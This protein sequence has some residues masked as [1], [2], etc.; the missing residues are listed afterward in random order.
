MARHGHAYGL[1]PAGYL[2]LILIPAE[3]FAFPLEL[4][5]DIVFLGGAIFVFIVINP[6]SETITKISMAGE[7][8][9]LLNDYL[10][11]RVVERTR[12]LKR[13]QEFV[14]TVLHGFN[15]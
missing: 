4:L 2:F 10:E 1:L 15:E 13:S 12:E 14:R 6:S 7:D 11:E 9:R 8:L 3:R 5:T